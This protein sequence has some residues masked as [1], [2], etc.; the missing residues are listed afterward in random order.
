MTTAASVEDAHREWATRALDATIVEVDSASSQVISG[1][2]ALAAHGPLLAVGPMDA[3]LVREALLAGADDYLD[4][5]SVAPATLGLALQAALGRREHRE[6]AVATRERRHLQELQTQQEKMRTALV[7]HLADRLLNPTT[8]IRL[9]ASILAK[10]AKGIE[11]TR[12]DQMQA[13]AERLRA[14]VEQ[15]AYAFE[16][17]AGVPDVAAAPRSLLEIHDRAVQAAGIEECKVTGDAVVEIDAAHVEEIMTTAL[18]WAARAAPG[19]L[20]VRITREEHVARYCIM[21]PSE[22]VGN[23]ASFFHPFH[24]LDEHQITGDL[25]LGLYAARLNARRMGGDLRLQDGSKQCL[26]LDLPLVPTSGPPTQLI[27]DATPRRGRW[28]GRT[29]NQS[30]RLLAA[31]SWHAARRLLGGSRPS[32]IIVGVPSDVDGGDLARLLKERYPEAQVERLP[33]TGQPDKVSVEPVPL[34]AA[35]HP[36]WVRRERAAGAQTNAMQDSGPGGLDDS[37]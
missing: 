6:R 23:Q 1:I 20:E 28:I 36:P 34:A 5:A 13:A 18:A 33:A 8:V 15:I 35:I 31:S 21:L 22:L 27:I 25:G 2:Q 10:E 4:E 12:L 29:E 9:Q 19:P 17:Q 16:A 7:N 37:T 24:G 26:E 11:A 14:T 30:E 32:R 3:G